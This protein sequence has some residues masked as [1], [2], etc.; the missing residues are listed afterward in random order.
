MCIG[1]KLLDE[2]DDE[3][4]SKLAKD[5]LKMSRYSKIFRTLQET[6]KGLDDVK[7]DAGD[8]EG[9]AGFSL[10]ALFGRGS[11]AVK[12]AAGRRKAARGGKETS[13]VE[14]PEAT[15]AL[16]DLD[17]AADFDSYTGGKINCC[18]Y[19]CEPL[20]TI[21]TYTGDYTKTFA[22]DDEEHVG[23]EQAQLEEREEHDAGQDLAEPEVAVDKDGRPVSGGGEEGDGD[24]DE[25]GDGYEEEEGAAGAGAE[26]GDGMVD[27]DMERVSAVCILHTVYP[28]R[29][30]RTQLVVARDRVRESMG[31][32]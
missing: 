5:K 31:A 8:D 23:A 22:D 9:L 30:N 7:A 14:F 16:M 4:D 20:L 26:T 15:E 11:A 12:A 19:P 21:L 6:D 27:Q 1:Q 25:E 17:A 32:C 24:S 10:P 3:F 28:M 29:L 18:A 2:I 13:Q